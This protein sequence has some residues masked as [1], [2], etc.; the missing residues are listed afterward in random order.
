MSKA[1]FK[2]EYWDKQ[3]VG[4]NKFFVYVLLLE[5]GKYYVGQT[6]HLD[7]RINQ[8]F[9]GYG[10][11]ITKKHKPIK[12]IAVGEYKTRYEVYYRENELRNLYK[13]FC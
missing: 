5:N 1:P 2:Q 7:H 12:T 11:L 8:H 4:I 9:L 10:A 6:G 3:D 13:S